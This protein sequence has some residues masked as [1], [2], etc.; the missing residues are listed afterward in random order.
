MS[1]K[2]PRWRREESNGGDLE[3][4]SGAVNAS[5]QCAWCV[6]KS[7]RISE[8]SGAA[9][10]PHHTSRFHAARNMLPNSTLLSLATVA[11]LAA[12]CFADDTF[13]PMPPVKAHTPAET[14]ASI[15][16]PPGYEAQVRPRSGIAVKHG[17]TVLNAPGTI[18][19]DYRG[20][21]KVLLINHGADAFVVTPGMRIAQLVVAEV[22]RVE[23]DQ[24]EDLTQTARGAGGFGHTGQ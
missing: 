5:R 6:A 22:A 24:S 2:R 9:Y 18:D 10:L 17:V 1:R 8:L 4:F 21:V 11:T 23:W 15:E 12:A 14:I 7:S 16:L 19:S 20:E 3:N 13:P